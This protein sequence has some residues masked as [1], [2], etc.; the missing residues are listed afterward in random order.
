MKSF[1][2]DSVIVG[3]DD[4]GRPI[5][6]RTYN[7]TDLSEQYA[8]FFSNGVFTDG[9]AFHVA[10]SDGMNVLVSPGK[11][12]IEGRVG[13]E[14]S[15][16]KLAIQA[17]SM[18]ADRIDT[19]VIRLDSNMEKRDIDLYVRTGVAAEV[20]VRP[21]LT[22]SERVYEIGLCDIYVP[23]NTSQVS[24]ERIT[25]TRLETGRCGVVA[26]FAPLETTNFYSQMNAQT[27]K[28]VE[29]A[30]AA[31]EGTLY[32][33]LA[34]MIDDA[35]ER[36]MQ[37]AHPVGSYYISNDA[38]SPETLFPGTT[39]EKIEGYFLRAASD[40]ATGGSDTVA[41]AAVNLPSHHHT[42][43]KHLHDMPHY[44]SMNFSSG[45]GGMHNHSI[46]NGNNYVLSS[47]SAAY[48]ASSTGSNA[49]WFGG[50]YSAKAATIST[51]D[52]HTHAVT[53][54]TNGQN[55]GTT[56][57]SSEFATGDTG[58][59]TAFSVMPKYQNAHI[60]RRTA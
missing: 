5:L 52:G 17:A 10:A 21:E 58:S 56:A 39:W 26:P 46:K 42:V 30:D 55:I 11:C 7:A 54:N 1:P 38:T 12:C 3:K 37:K 40:T 20:P 29:L 25:D 57:Y 50:G 23:K 19:V 41:L 33:T 24:Q 27:Q 2:W 49:P 60:W 45:A 51:T 31:L 4:D 13:W 36:A 15:D 14:L 32:E 28:A 6:D 9:D 53:G 35:E 59:G 34:Q 48:G 22:R 16:R 43:G 47:G 18:S 44:H 8:T